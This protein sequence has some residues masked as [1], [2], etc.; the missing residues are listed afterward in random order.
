[1]ID[2]VVAAI[3]IWIAIKFSQI[4]AWEKFFDSFSITGICAAVHCDGDGTTF[5]LRISNIF[6]MPTPY[7]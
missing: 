4:K 7:F 5:A 3:G 2:T 1:M 6:H